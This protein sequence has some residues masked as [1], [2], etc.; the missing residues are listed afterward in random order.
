M[1]SATTDVNGRAQ[2]PRPSPTEARRE[3]TPLLILAQKGADMSFMPLRSNG[4]ELDLSRFDTGGVESARS[5]QQLSTYLFSDRGIYRPGETT[6]LGVITRTADW[7]A[8]L[9]GLPLMVD[10]TDPRGLV[11]GHNEVKLS[12]A[13]FD[14]VT[15]TSQPTAPTGTYQAVAYLVRSDRRRETLGSTSFKVQEFEPDRLKVRLDS[16]T[17]SASLRLAG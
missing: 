13:S 14:E 3:K 4:R 1:L 8:S 10:I 16:A 15:Y 6:H 17:R 7:K 2:L 12:P 9:A 5:A 11:V